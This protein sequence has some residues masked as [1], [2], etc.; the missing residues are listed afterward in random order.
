MD[1]RPSVELRRK[2]IDA[3]FDETFRGMSQ[4]AGYTAP[5]PVRHGFHKSRTRHQRKEFGDLKI[6]QSEDQSAEEKQPRCNKY[7]TR[8]LRS[9]YS[10]YDIG[11]AAGKDRFPSTKK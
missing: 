8:K 10:K 5:V 7:R 11:P 4:V 9:L 1:H 3:E 2:Q 6:D